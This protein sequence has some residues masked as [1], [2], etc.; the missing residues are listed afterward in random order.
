MYRVLRPGGRAIVID[1]DDGALVLHPRPEL[2]MNALAARQLTFQRRGAD[3][4]IGRRLP[5]LFAGAGFIAAALRPL[6]LDSVSLGLGPFARIVLA[7]VADAI[8]AD[9]LDA[10]GVRAAAA[11]IE[12]WTGD[13]SAF[14]MTTVVVYGGSKR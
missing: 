5:A 13:P 3:P 9:L 14:G 4:F 10:A 7:P 1:T 8:D 2:F 6:V 12:A 11:A